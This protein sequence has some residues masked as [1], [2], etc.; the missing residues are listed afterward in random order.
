MARKTSIE[1]SMLGDE[2]KFNGDAERTEI[3]RAFHY[4]SYKYSIRD[5]KKWITQWMKDNGYT[6]DDISKYSRSSHVDITQ[7]KASIARMLT[8]GLR[9]CPMQKDLKSHIDTV[10][11]HK[12]LVVKSLSVSN[13]PIN[14][15]ITDIDEILDDFYLQN[16][17]DVLEF[18]VASDA[19][20]TDIKAAHTYYTDL[21]EE[22]ST[23][24]E[25]YE[26]LNRNQKKRYKETLENIISELVLKGALAKRK[27]PVRKKRKV[28]VE[29][30][31]SKVK[32]LKQY[33]AYTSLDPSVIL[34]SNIIW[35][36]NTKTR[37][38]AKYKAPLGEKL[39]IKGTTLQNVDSSTQYT[40]RKPDEFLPTIITGGKRAVDQAIK[41]IT[42]KASEPNGRLND[43]TI[44]V[45]A[46]K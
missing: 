7:T 44:I 1:Q 13:K 35:V 39:Q 43:T 41:K 30:Q 37:K 24:K 6:T 15:V 4:Y 19:R 8:Q 45:R 14:E 23:Q 3:M 17:K 12:E 11:E 42:T 31:V 9:D 25:G 40:L 27:T 26:H 21:L 32:Y 16:Y 5:S 10:L 33:E 29:K 18:E 28:S 46:F 38:L 22:I 34:D 20:V 2:P 36:F